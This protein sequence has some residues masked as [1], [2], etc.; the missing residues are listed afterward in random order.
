MLT[1]EDF[2]ERETICP[3]PLSMDTA[4]SIIFGQ[5][6]MRR[7][8]FLQNFRLAQPFSRKKIVTPLSSQACRSCGSFLILLSPDSTYHSPS[9]PRVPSH[10]KLPQKPASGCLQKRV[11]SSYVD[12]PTST[13]EPK[14]DALYHYCPTSSFHAI[15]SSLSIGLSSHSLSND[16]QEGKLVA[17]AFQTLAV[18]DNLDASCVER[19]R[20][21]LDF[22]ESLAEGLGANR[23]EKAPFPFEAR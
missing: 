14:P 19:L 15:I 2:P 18:R 4:W 7:D 21:S 5:C 10:S 6:S 12:R 13:G 22:L 3:D 23:R 20:Q 1:G 17:D 16:T 8:A 11:N 9:S